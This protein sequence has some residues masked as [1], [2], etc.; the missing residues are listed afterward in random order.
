MRWIVCT[1]VVIILTAC[2]G[3]EEN[4]AAT[5][6][7]SLPTGQWA[8]TAEVTTF[9][10]A[11]QGTPQI[12]TPVGT[13]TTESVCVGAGRPPEALFAGAGYDCT[14]DSFYARNG[15]M[16]VTMICRR[17]GLNGSI[18]TTADGQFQADSLEYTRDMRTALSGDGD[19]QI[20]Q[21]VTGRRTGDCTPAPAESNASAEKSG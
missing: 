13:R 17:E 4:K 10:K 2:G 5:K 1:T 9:T 15:R 7:A 20:R 8:L 3:A 6:A 14:Y 11:D 21:R 19:V 16:N 12:D 18:P